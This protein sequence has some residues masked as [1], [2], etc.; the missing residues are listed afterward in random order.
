MDERYEDPLQQESSRTNEDVVQQQQQN[1]VSIPVPIFLQS[2][3]EIFAVIGIFAA[4]TT[5]IPRI[6]PK[7][8]GG[9]AAAPFAVVGGLMIFVLTG[10]I[11]FIRAAEQMAAASREHKPLR[12]GWY[13]GIEVSFV[14]LGAAVI[15]ALAYRQDAVSSVADFSLAIGAALMYFTII[16]SYEF[17]DDILAPRLKYIASK[18]RAIAFIIVFA[19][20]SS[21]KYPID[22][23]SEPHLAVVGEGII[24]HFVLSFIISIAAETVDSNL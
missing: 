23:S 14:M 15:Q 6:L 1:E 10:S 17:G 24:W 13:F 22:I 3:S 16:R 18:S 9:D 8:T 21:P 12:V 4:V 11:M 19:M 7:G 20:A 5:S 2:N